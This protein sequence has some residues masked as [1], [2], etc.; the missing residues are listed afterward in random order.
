MK[1]KRSAKNFHME[2][3]EIFT[4]PPCRSVCHTLDCT[5]VRM[6]ISL[7]TNFNNTRKYD[8]S[9]SISHWK[10]MRHSENRL[11]MYNLRKYKLKKLKNMKN[12]LSS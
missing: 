9:I 8:N 11:K 2:L 10:V 5:S 1:T 6:P 7:L 3:A 12:W 4:F